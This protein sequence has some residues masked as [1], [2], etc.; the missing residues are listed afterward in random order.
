VQAAKGNDLTVVLTNAAWK[1]DNPGQLELLRALRREN[2]PVV[3]AAVRDPYDA[4]HV[5]QVPTWLA[6]YS[7]KPVA[8]E[9]LAKVLFGETTPRGKLPVTVPDPDHPGAD[10]F[11][12]GH[13][14]GW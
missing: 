3:A 1:P 9:S 2:L 4:A 10:R 12:L 5:E 11:P 7:D 14:L 6:T 8:M 13:G